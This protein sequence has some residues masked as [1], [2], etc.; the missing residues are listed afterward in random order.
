MSGRRG[1]TRQGWCLPE[2]GTTPATTRTRGCRARSWVF[3]S[4]DEG[5]VGPHVSARKTVVHS[6]VG[7]VTCDRDVLTVP[8]CDIRLV[9]HT[10]AAG[11]ADAEKLEFLQVTGGVRADGLQ[12]QDESP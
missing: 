12:P 10:V 11:S 5:A 9:V 4:P 2:G 6:Q 8:G 7:E 1:R 3:G